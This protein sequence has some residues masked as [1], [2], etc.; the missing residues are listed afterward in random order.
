MTVG[1]AGDRDDVRSR[2]STTE[3]VA[4]ARITERA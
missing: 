3:I 1:A 4:T 2:R